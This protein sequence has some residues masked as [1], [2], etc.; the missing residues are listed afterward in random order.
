VRAGVHEA[1]IAMAMVVW[2]LIAM[3][4]RGSH[5]AR[6]I[7]WSGSEWVGSEQ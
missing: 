5:G 7:P 6:S 4:E 2:Q 3:L 1:S